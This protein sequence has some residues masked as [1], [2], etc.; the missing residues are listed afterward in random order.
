MHLERPAHRAAPELV[1][2]LFVTALL[3]TSVVAPASAEKLYLTCSRQVI[4]VHDLNG[5]GDAMD[6]GEVSVFADALPGDVTACCF[7][8]GVLYAVDASNSAIIA[9]ADEN[10][11]GDAMDAGEVRLFADVSSW[12]SGAAPLGLAIDGEDN[13]YTIHAY[14]GRLLRIT[15]LNGDGDAFDVLEVQSVADG[16]GGG[17]AI[18]CRS[19]ATLLIAT[20]QL[21]APVRVLEDR[22]IDGDFFDF[23]ENLAYAESFSPGVSIVA[24]DPLTSLIGRNTAPQILRLSDANAD[25]DVMDYNEVLGFAALSGNVNAIARGSSCD[26]FVATGTTSGSI[27]CVTDVNGDGD[28]LDA[29]ETS[30]FVSALPAIDGMTI[31]ATGCIPGDLNGDGRLDATDAGHLASV[32][33]ELTPPP[34]PCRADL[35]EDGRID[36]EDIKPFVEVLLD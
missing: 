14:E 10:S 23:A 33:L 20:D 30:L 31:V 1:H 26:L 16:L 2:C 5:D 4:T 34:D 15:D 24:I 28:A 7:A 32:L 22:N 29:G 17:V 18:A 13:L 36:G 11:D 9:L 27:Q 25:G 3:I 12:L 35:N 21:S 8:S 6:Y 19:D